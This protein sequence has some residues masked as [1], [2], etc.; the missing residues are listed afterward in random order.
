MAAAKPVVATPVDGA[1]DLVEP[2]A[3]G[4]IAAAIGADELADALRVQL[5][6][7]DVEMREQGR[8][9]RERLVARHT[10][11]AMVRGLASVYREVT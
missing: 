4:E 9:A 1:I 2:G 7:G 3:T 6:R 11:E 10:S 5:G 8:R